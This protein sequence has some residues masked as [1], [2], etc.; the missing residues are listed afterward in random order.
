MGFG[1]RTQPARRKTGMESSSGNWGSSGSK[2]APTRRKTGTGIRQ[3][4]PIKGQDW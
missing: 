4:R 1:R 2:T 3:I